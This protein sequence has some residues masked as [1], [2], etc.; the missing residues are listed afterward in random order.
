MVPWEKLA[1]AAAEDGTTLELR[2]RGREVVISAGGLELMSSEDAPSSRA[3][4]ELGCRDLPVGRPRRVLV[5]GLGMGFTLRAALDLLQPE[6]RVDLAELVQA[7]VD[8]NRGGFGIGELA[9]HP[10][11]DP[12]TQLFRGDVLKLVRRE[13]GCFDV[14]LLDVDN[15]PIAL[16]HPSND[17]LYGPEGIALCCDALAE[18]GTLAVWSLRDDPRFTRRL[19][20]E[21]LGVEVH[22]VFGS[23]RG[24]GKQHVIW[25][26]RRA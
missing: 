16:A 19:Q 6:D 3:L 15:G 10:L 4:A 5:G 25:T 12:R 2:R 26:A 11:D 24:R 13:P 17:A 23:R 8:W 22:R 21:G 14:I 7:V 18:G 1:S 20:A 9:G